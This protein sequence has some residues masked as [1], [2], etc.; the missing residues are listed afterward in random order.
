MINSLKN[1]SVVDTYTKNALIL[2]V[3]SA[4]AIG[5]FI[6][7][8]S[9]YEFIQDSKLLEQENL[10]LHKATLQ[11]EITRVEELIKFDRS[12]LHS[13]IRKNIKD[14]VYE[15][16]G[17]A[18]SLYEK[19][20][21]SKSRNEIEALIIDALRPHRFFE[22]RGYFYAISLDGIGKLNPI[23]PQFEGTNMLAF[24]T[25]KGDYYIKELI[26][27]TKDNG[28][29]F[30]EHTW[31]KPNEAGVFDK[32]S[33]V[34][35]FEP[36]D[37]LIG[38]GDYIID[39]ERQIQQEILEQIGKIRFGKEGYIFVVDYDG[40]VLM[41]M[42]QPS[43]IGNN[44]IN[45]TDP[46]GVKVISEVIKLAQDPS[47]DGFFSYSWEKRTT[48]K[49]APKTS[50]H[51]TVPEWG[52]YYGAGVYTD[53]IIEE[54]DQQRVALEQNLLLHLFLIIT[55]IS[56]A[57]GILLY[58]SKK[59]ASELNND[60]AHL[61]N[62]FEHLSVESQPLVIDK[63]KYLEFKQL[64]QSANL[65]LEK[66]QKSE[67][68][69]LKYEE[70][71]LQNQKMAAIH[72]MVGGISHDFN[73]L[74]GAILGFG[75]L[76]E[77]KL[78]DN[79]QLKSYAHQINTA[80]KRG[81]NL[82]KKLLSLTRNNNVEVE[83]TD[84]NSILKEEEDLLRKS[85]TAK[86]NITLILKDE[87]WPVLINK[88]DLE[89]VILNLCVNAMHAM[90]EGQQDS[91]IIISTDHTQIPD[92]EAKI[93]DLNPGDY[94]R[95][96]VS[97]NGVGMDSK[98]KER[99]FEPFFTTR[100]TGHGLGLSQVYSFARQSK[101][102]VLVQS[103][104]GAGT[105]F[106]ILIPRVKRANDLSKSSDLLDNM[107]VKG[108]ETILVVD[109]ESALREFS[110]VILSDKGYRVL[111]AE[112]GIEAL[113]IL[114]KEIVDLVL[115]DVIMPN[116][117]GSVLADK[118]SK[119]YPHIKTQLVSGYAKLEDLPKMNQNLYNN[120]LYKPVKASDL[121]QRVRVLLN[122]KSEQKTE[123]EPCLSD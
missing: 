43:L 23:T 89:D 60:L 77:L 28:E 84:I 88:S 74:L 38:T 61:L 122:E 27:I 93:Y 62:F 80:G 96:S 105:T 106:Q 115:S 79:Q 83:N 25:K 87:L 10:A 57:I 58:L 107:D 34:K 110:S 15:A 63:L 86:I 18:T 71:I 50:Y 53:D 113:I 101:G 102:T 97:D 81:A 11:R 5:G 51:K 20:K 37:W 103:T 66:Q 55:T 76:L 29:G 19:Y 99:I 46:N 69:R 100:E 118:I 65:M 54:I 30:Y 112:N 78:D 2:I 56:L 94:V 42:A 35:H 114:E 8:F 98:T 119:L 67:E 21:N 39:V 73:N 26:N 22:N 48:S 64:A 68:Q 117:D 24:K 108:Q 12:K 31:T 120:L 1:K 14:R 49:I 104:E 90:R 47:W 92:D 41:N 116:M 3:L 121:L 4:V 32:V 7:F 40:T 16:H 91:E 109:D 59:R 70:Q 17:I 72:Q 33:F 111:Q 85:L 52:W 13:R 75:E 123:K 44:I 6:S 45:M 36:Y 82:T 95:I 9:F